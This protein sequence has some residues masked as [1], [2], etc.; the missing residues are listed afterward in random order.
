MIIEV[1]RDRKSWFLSIVTTD[2]AGAR[3]GELRSI[4]VGL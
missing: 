4:P 3:D 1:Q 2:T